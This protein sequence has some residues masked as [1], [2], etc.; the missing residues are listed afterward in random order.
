MEMGTGKSKVAIDFCCAMHLKAG[1]KRV[2]IVC[3][4]SVIG[5]WR[6]EIRKHEPAFAKGR[7]QWLIVNYDK[8]ADRTVVQGDE[9]WE[10][11]GAA[12]KLIDW[13]P[14]VLIADES[15][16]M[17]R[18]SAK[19][20]RA[21][22]RMGKAAKFRLI[23][24]GTPVAKNP[25]DLYSQFKFLDE[26]VFG[27]NFNQFKRKYCVFGGYGNYK[28]LRY[29]NLDDLKKRAERHVFQITKNECLDL[30]SRTH[31]I[32]P[33][34]LDER[35]REFY[36]KMR[37]GTLTKFEGA[38]VVTPIMLTQ[39]LRL[40]QMTSGFLNTENGAKRLGEEKQAK[41]LQ[42]LE[43]M[44]SQEREK[45]VIFCRFKH[46]LKVSFLA[47]KQ[48]GYRPMLFHGKTKEAEREQ[49]LVE[50]EESEDSIAFIAQIAT[51][52]LGISLTAASEAIFFSH[53]YRYDTF[54]Q[55]CDRLHRIGQHSPVS[56]YHLI[57]QDS[58]DE[59]VWMALRA[60]K[61]VA[62]LVL[63]RP[64]LLMQNGYKNVT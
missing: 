2:V 8:L 20:S 52:S 41:L 51:G 37:K 26:S 1:V 23:L 12:H 13:E 29:I 11:E 63:R 36:E 46:D 39:L 42:V 54:V 38:E 5:V 31:E 18:A 6:L 59:V 48:A 19:R 60:K 53:D 40:S 25:L 33:V 15:H 17:K 45:V 43:D 14:D 64:V 22:Y 10:Y 34:R 55:A 7:I 61:D 58:I 27:N 57:C 47:A 35:S 49:K 24:T 4:K 21:M 32:I 30:P 9:E 44:K 16:L 56:Y 3:P 50:F 62:E 28:L